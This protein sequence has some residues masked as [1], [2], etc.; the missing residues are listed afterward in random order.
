MALLNVL[1]APVN[2]FIQRATADGTSAT[3]L[4]GTRWTLF[5]ILMGGLLA[6]P[7]F[8]AAFDVKWP[9]ARDVRLA[10]LLGALLFGPA[11]AL[12]YY[13]LAKTST[14]EGTVINTTAPIWTTILAFL[15]LRERG[16]P[17]RTASLVLG[18]LG[19]YLV[20]IGPQLPDLATGHTQGNLL[21][22]S[23]TVTECLAGVFAVAIVRRSSGLPVLW[24]QS[25]GAAVALAAVALAF[26]N[27]FPWRYDS[28]GWPTYTSLAYMVLVA[29]LITFGMWYRLV[30]KA[31]LSL[32]V[33]SL[34]MQPPLSALIGHYGL[35]EAVGPNVWLGLAPILLALLVAANERTL[36]ARLGQEVSR[37]EGGDG[38]DRG[39]GHDPVR[40][41][42]PLPEELGREAA[43]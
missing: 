27:V 29:G 7:R 21:Y 24:L 30:E 8:R 16:N 28:V 25:I 34:M 36:L 31:P 39:D 23:A 35:G 6:W 38:D 4:A 1:W 15:V 43:K 13:A 14:I 20:S 33:I 22:L 41:Q 17:V 18:V 42:N 11:H 32:M 9:S 5:G 10:L 37:G 2:Y 3:A 40:I 26:P 19:A 12:Y